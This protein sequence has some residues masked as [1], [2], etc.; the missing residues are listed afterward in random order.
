M[1]LLTLVSQTVLVGLLG[2][3]LVIG[4]YENIRAP[5]VNLALVRDVFSMDA[6]AEEM[7][8]VYEMVKR[9]RVT[10]EALQN[11][12]FRLI[13]AFETLVAAGLV[14]GTVMLGLAIFGAVDAAYAQLFAGWAV[15]GFILIWGLFLVGGNWF[16]YWVSHKATQHTHYFMTFWGILTLGWLV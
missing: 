1:E 12:L 7:P 8:G 5:E 4:A 2:G 11:G 10:S 15:L 9:N 16:H 13:V 14:L 6:I 3:W